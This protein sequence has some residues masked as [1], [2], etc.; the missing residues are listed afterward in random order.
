MRPSRGGAGTYSLVSQE[1]MPLFPC[2]PEIKWFIPQNYFVLFPI[3]QNRIT[4]SLV[5][6][7]H[8]SYAQVY[9][10]FTPLHVQIFILSADDEFGFKLDSR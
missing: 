2:S 4:S 9:F 7:K 6:P 1:N 3:L 10:I 8:I 5:P